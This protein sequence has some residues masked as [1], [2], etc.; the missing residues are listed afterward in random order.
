M[1]AGQGTIVNYKVLSG[2]GDWTE[3]AVVV[4]THQSWTSDFG[5]AAGL[6][7]PNT[8]TVLLLVLRSG[9]TI[10]NVAE[11]TSDGEYTL[12]CYQVTASG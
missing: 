4:H 10:N 5:T 9:Q 2:V 7:Q 8:G 1:S 11:G 6:S 12:P 3:P